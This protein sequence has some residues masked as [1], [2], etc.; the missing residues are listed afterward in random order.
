MTAYRLVG[1]ND[2]VT[3]CECCGKSNLKCT[4]VLGTDG[5]EVRFGRDCAARALAGAFGMVKSATRI[6]NDARNLSAGHRPVKRM[7]RP[8]FFPNGMR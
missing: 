6:E 2:E 3:T 1:I 7:P 8:Y 5:G 4:V